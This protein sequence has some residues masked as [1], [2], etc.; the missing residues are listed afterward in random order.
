MARYGFAVE[1]VIDTGRTDKRGNFIID[2]K[3]SH[4]E[5]LRSAIECYNRSVSMGG[6]GSRIYLLKSNSNRTFDVLA[7]A[8]SDSSVIKMLDFETV[9]ASLRRGLTSQSTLEVF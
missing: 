7:I 4:F 1:R 5:D 8:D 9:S 2:K 6:F 3:Y